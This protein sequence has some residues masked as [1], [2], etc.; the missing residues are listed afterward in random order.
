[1]FNQ[2]P[3]NSL[4]DLRLL[5]LRNSVNL[6]VR[7]MLVELAQADFLLE[8]THLSTIPEHRRQTY[9]SSISAGVLLVTSGSMNHATTT[10]IAPVAA[11]LS[12]HQYPVQGSFIK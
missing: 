12:N 3:L 6:H 1:M 5:S 2:T 9:S 7:N 10:D 4:N 8:P 11:K